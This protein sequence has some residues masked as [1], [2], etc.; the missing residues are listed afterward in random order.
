MTTG[1]TYGDLYIA[2][3]IANAAGRK[4]DQ[5]VALKM[6]GQT[7]DKIADANNVSFGG[8]KRKQPEMARRPMLPPS[9]T[10]QSDSRA[11]MESWH[12]NNHGR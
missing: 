3:A 2:H 11:D 1:L 10:M 6:Q 8:T 12:P 9:M 5:I 4:F 7:W